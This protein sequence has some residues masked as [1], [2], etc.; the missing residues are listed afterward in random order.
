MSDDTKVFFELSQSLSHASD[1]E[2]AEL[3]YAALERFDP[4]T[5]LFSGS[6]AERIRAWAQTKFLTV[7]ESTGQQGKDL[8]R[9]L[10]DEPTRNDLALAAAVAAMLSKLAGFEGLPIE[11][12]VALSLLVVRLKR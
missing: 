5:A 3:A 7:C 9:T 2:L 1:R 4:Q 8:L 12:I 11:G 6:K 10:T